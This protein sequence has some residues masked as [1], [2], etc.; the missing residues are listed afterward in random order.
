MNASDVPVNI[1]LE[2]ISLLCDSDSK[3]KFFVSAGLD[4][5]YQYLLQGYPN[6]IA[7]AAKVLCMFGSTYLCEQVLYN[8]H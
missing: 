3:G 6:L 2:I 4:T 8:G 1:Q 5:F 7:L